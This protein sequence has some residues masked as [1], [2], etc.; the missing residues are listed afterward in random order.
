MNIKIFDTD[1]TELFDRGNI[2][3]RI[4]SISLETMEKTPVGMVVTKEDY[5]KKLRM[6]LY[7]PILFIVD[8]PTKLSYIYDCLNRSFLQK[9]SKVFLFYWRELGKREWAKWFAVFP[10]NDSVYGETCKVFNVDI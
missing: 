4:D 10:Y 2:V 3:F 9:R 5:E 7:N 8:L 6:H 1:V